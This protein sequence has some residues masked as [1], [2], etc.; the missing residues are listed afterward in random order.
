MQ[1][2]R[3]LEHRGDALGR[4][5]RIDGQV[6][7]AGLPH[8]EHG[9]EQRGAAGDADGDAGVAL[10]AVAQ[11][12]LGDGRSLVKQF[13]IREAFLLTGKGNGI[14]LPRTGLRNTLAHW[15]KRITRKR[16]RLALRRTHCQRAQFDLRSSNHLI[17]QFDEVIRH[18]LD[19]RRRENI[20]GEIEVQA[21]VIR[22]A[23]DVQFQI[24]LHRIR[25]RIARL[26]PQSGQR[27]R[28]RCRLLIVEHHLKQRR[29]VAFAVR[30]QRFDEP[31]ERQVRVSVRVERALPDVRDQCCERVRAADVRRHHQRVHEATDH[32]SSL[33]L[34][35][36]RNRYADAD[37][38]LSAIALQQDVE[39]REHH[40]KEAS[41]M[42]F[43]EMTQRLHPR[44]VECA[45]GA[46]ESTPPLC[47][48]RLF[49]RQFEDGIG[50]AK[51]V[52]PIA[53]LARERRVVGVQSLPARV[54]A[55][56]HAQFGQRGEI[57][58]VQRCAIQ[59]D[60][61]VDQQI[62]RLAISDD[63]MQGEMQH[64]VFGVDVNQRDAQQRI[65]SQIERCTRGIAQS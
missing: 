33:D 64:M 42:R 50:F 19:R 34:R 49:E 55:V 48:A 21:R 8:A 65:A 38:V 22:C 1:H 16:H 5:G 7:R 6:G 39:C 10:H 52:A 27:L 56:L 41:L 3:I 23:G 43:G 61:L 20:I 35:A 11:Q 36:A 13:T 24:E 54:I 15:H 59:R 25:L 53:E 14:R 2:L 44:G 51:Q 29:R 9:G 40:D 63:V 58:V 26:D 62:D 17:D 57:G 18:P 28:R 12:P 4:I 46:A 47:R 60:Q 31:R 32:P 45:D 30:L 37:L